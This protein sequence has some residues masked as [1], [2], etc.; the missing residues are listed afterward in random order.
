MALWVMPPFFAH[1]DTKE[2][3]HEES[4][5][6]GTPVRTGDHPDL[7][8]H[9]YLHQGAAG[10]LPAGGDLVHPLRPGPH[11]PDCG[12][13]PPAQRH[14]A[15]AGADLCRRRPVRRV[16]ILSAGEYRPDLYLGLQCGRH[17]LR[18]PLLHRH[19]V[20]CGVQRRGE[21]APQLLRRLCAGHGGHRPHQLQ[22][23]RP[24]SQPHG[25]PAGTAGGVGVGLLLHP[26]Q[27]DQ[28]LWLLHSYHHPAGVLLRHR[29]HDP[30]HV[31]L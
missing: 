4:A 23:L 24:V 15:P 13:P 22:R 7:G 21:A 9:L 30:R 5:G 8:Y 11:R 26:H 12:M 31:P 25:R 14:H 1:Q 17:P 16:P 28:R 29:L 27:E 20:P 10:G 2:R 19:F 6:H 3:D 18:G